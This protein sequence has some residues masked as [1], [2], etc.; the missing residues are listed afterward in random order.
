MDDL[1]IEKTENVV[2]R[3]NR[4]RKYAGNPILVA[5]RS[6]EGQG[7]LA[8]G[9]VLAD[10]TGGTGTPR[11]RMW[12]RGWV[13]TGEAFHSPICLAESVDGVSWV[14]PTFGA[15]DFGPEVH[16]PPEKGQPLPP[17]RGVPGT[18]IVWTLSH[19]CFAIDRDPDDPPRRYKL[20]AS[21]F[22]WWQGLTS[23]WSPDGIRW[24]LQKQYAVARL[25][26]RCSYWYDP[27]RKKHVAWSRCWSLIPL[28]VIVQVES[29]DFE[30]WG[31]PLLAI[32]PDRYDRED[33][34]LY[35]GGAFRYESMYLGYLEM[36]WVDSRRL[37]TQ[38]ISSRDGRRWERAGRRETFIDNGYHGEFDAYWAFPTSNP[39]IRIGDK[40][41]I[42]YTGRPDPHAPP[43]HV[44]PG[45]RGSIGLCTLRVDGF[46]SVDATGAEGT[47]TTKP[48]VFEKGERLTVNAC[49]MVGQSG[50]APMQLRVEVLD[51]TGCPV[52]GYGKDDAIVVSGDRL[53]HE[54]RWRTRPSLAELAGR[55]LRLRFYLFNSRLYSFRVT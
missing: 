33:I 23:A 13:Q 29:D 1:L 36:Y 42:H 52:P 32:Q 54:I 11:L 41:Y 2:K 53:D 30:N 49:P 4:P 40:L 28:R 47:L 3:L 25:G 34:Q 27:V 24:T 50:Y 19:D 51:E 9:S 5:E 16:L 22:D 20:L 8:Y 39:P 17:L 18:N 37:D 14:K 46:V 35:G 48:I 44:P 43:R 21:A 26:D 38:L 12:Y 6:W 15:Q 45:M 7:V 55:P 10:S 31:P